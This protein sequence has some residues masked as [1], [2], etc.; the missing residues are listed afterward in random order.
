MGLL[1]LF[2]AQMGKA[3]KGQKK[4]KKP[5]HRFEVNC[6]LP[7]SDNYFVLKDFAQYMQNNIKVEGK[8]ANLGK[9]VTVTT[10]SFSVIVNAT[11]P[12]SKR[13][14]KYLTKKFL[15]KQELRNFLRAVALNKNTYQLRYLNMN[16]DEEAAE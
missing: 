4:G 11:I 12:F 16:M 10:D 13:Y 9:Q 8:K 15:K 5:N 2:K 7:I 3:I 6:E 14:L 1:I